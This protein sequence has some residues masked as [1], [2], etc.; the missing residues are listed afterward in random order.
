MSGVKA[1]EMTGLKH[2][3]T[4][5]SNDRFETDKTSPLNQAAPRIAPPPRQP[6]LKL[7]PP[8]LY[9]Y[10][11]AIIRHGSFRSAAEALRIASSALNR[12]VL[13]LE[14]EVGTPLFERLPGGL[15]LTA[16]GE[17]FATH[18]RRTLSE[19][20]QV[21]EQLQ[22]MQGQLHGN[23]AIAAAESAAV[24]L[25]PRL[26]A[27]FQLEFPG[28]RF[29]VAVGTP[30]ELLAD[31]LADRV[32]LI[33]THEDPAHP[34]AAV[35][36]APEQPFCALMR[37]DHPLAG[38]DTLT[39]SDCHAFPI[40]LAAQDLAARGLV[41]AALSAA[42]VTIR[43]V[44]VTNMF[45]V[46]KRYVAMTDAISFQFHLQST[47]A[48]QALPGLVAVRLTDPKLAQARLSLAARRART[49]PAGAAKFGDWLR[50]AMRGGTS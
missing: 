9:L 23:I 25:L 21:G 43:P 35:L 42:A 22:D 30:R 26:M 31:L 47:A 7:P 6:A 41:D 1:A 33:L 34:D 37:A 44:L 2:S 50:D 11:D 4:H 49:L 17:V 48:A 18:V 15:R 39:I 19:L 5:S 32:D 10:F 3:R 46:M 38:R 16:A 14:R 20:Q 29:T 36:A 28:T 8:R 24:D 45:E 13:D 12:R 27:A 40:V